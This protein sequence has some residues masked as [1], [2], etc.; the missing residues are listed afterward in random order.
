MWY[1]TDYRKSRIKTHFWY[2]YGVKIWL[3]NQLNNIKGIYI[4][5]P[6]TMQEKIWFLQIFAWF[7]FV[8]ILERFWI[9]GSVLIIL[10]VFL[11]VDLVFWVLEVYLRNKKEV[12]SEKMGSG[13]RKKVTRRFLPFIVAT[14]LHWTGI[15]GVWTFITAIMSILIATEFYSIVGH[16]YSINTWKQ[17]PEIDAFEMLI[18]KIINLIKKTIWTNTKPEDKPEE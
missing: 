15:E 4:L 2:N 7:S 8:W 9:D 6:F 11:L 16:I 1:D 14:G 12:S 3:L 17:L 18:E 10:T 13:V 5:S